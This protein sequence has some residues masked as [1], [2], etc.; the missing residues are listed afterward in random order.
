M[1]GQNILIV[2]WFGALNNPTIEYI[3]NGITGGKGG[4]MELQLHLISRVLNIILFST[5]EI[6]YYVVSQL[7]HLI[8]YMTIAM[9]IYLIQ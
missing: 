6:L 9:F 4:A 8:D 3:S 7:A 1:H 2:A 5:I